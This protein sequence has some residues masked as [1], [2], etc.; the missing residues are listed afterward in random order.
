MD[1]QEKMVW[2][3]AYVRELAA[4]RRADW[5]RRYHP[6]EG[7]PVPPAGSLHQKAVICADAAV[8]ELRRYQKEHDGDRHVEPVLNDE[9]RREQDGTHS[10]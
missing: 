5:E 9:R 3:A 8:M 2:A 4:A 7:R 6:Q 10:A 1:Q